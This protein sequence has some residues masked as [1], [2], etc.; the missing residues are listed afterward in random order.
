M[1]SI[2]AYWK[3]TCR[4]SAPFMLRAV[5]LNRLLGGSGYSVFAESWFLCFHPLLL[6]AYERAARAHTVYLGTFFNL[7]YCNK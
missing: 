1:I 5:L 6:F 4:I 2:I 7:F 3:S